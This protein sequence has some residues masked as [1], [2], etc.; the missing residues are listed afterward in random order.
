MI[1]ILFLVNKFAIGGAETI[2][3]NQINLI[4]KNRFDPYLGILYRTGKTA[5]LY[6]RLKIP[7]EKVSH[8]DFKKLADPVGFFR[9]YRF[10]KFGKFDAVVSHLF[11]ANF[12]GRLAAIFAGVPLIFATE[13]SV[14]K[15]RTLWQRLADR[16]LAGKTTMIIAVSDTVARFTAGSEKIPAEKI[17]VLKQL[18]D[19]NLAA[20]F[21]RADLRQKFE[22]PES[23]LLAVTLGRFS[24]EKAPERV[25][26]VAERLR[27]VNRLD[28]FFLLVGYGPME[29]RLRGLIEEKNLGQTVKMAVD[30]KAAREY[31]PAGEVFLLPSDREGVPIA[32]LE[33]MSLG[34]V[35]IASKVG[36]VVDVIKSEA[37]GFAVSPGDTETMAQKLVYLADGRD[38]LERRKLSAKKAAGEQTGKIEELE[39]LIGRFSKDY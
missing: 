21:S 29:G 17:I 5:T 6:D 16:L 28:I 8:F 25:I 7:P 23:G 22:I 15:N 11:E 37:D 36:G 14:Y 12:V 35:P 34:L 20:K 27:K 13:H 33:G 3:L 4:D 31:L 19:F 30:P 32:L 2:A 24:P 1:K 10:L 38:E 9:L 26:A 39:Q 18:V